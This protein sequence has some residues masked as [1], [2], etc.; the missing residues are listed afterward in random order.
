MQ[1]KQILF[2]NYLQLLGA[3][4]HK[5]LQKFCR[6]K[7]IIFYYRHSGCEIVQD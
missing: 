6:V 4:Q 1:K 2:M 5:I 3:F 7:G